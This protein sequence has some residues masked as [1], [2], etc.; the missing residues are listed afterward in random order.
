MNLRAGFNIIAH[1]QG[2]LLARAFVQR[3]DWPQVDTLVSWVGP[4]AGQFGVPTYEPLLGYMNRL[5]SGLWY[6]KNLQS[7]SGRTL[8]FSNYW[9][10]PTKLDMYRANSGFLA[11]INNE[12][13]VKN[14]SYAERLARLSHF[15]LVY[16][17]ADTIIQPAISSWFGFYKDNS[18]EV[19]EPLA[20]RK[21][22]TEDWIGLKR[23]D[24]TGRLH[25]GAVDCPH[26]G[27]ATARCKLQV[28]DQITKG[29]LAP[30]GGIEGLLP[31]LQGSPAQT[32]RPRGYSSSTMPA[33]AY[34]HIRKDVKPG[35]GSGPGGSFAPSASPSAP[36]E[37]GVDDDDDAAGYESTS[38]D[39][40]DGGGGG[41]GRSGGDGGGGGHSRSGGGGRDEGKRRRVRVGGFG[42]MNVLG[43]L[44]RGSS[45]PGDQSSPPDYSHL[46]KEELSKL[47][48]ELRREME[49]VERAEAAAARRGENAVQAREAAE[50]AA[51]R[52][53]EGNAAAKAKAAAARA[54]QAMLEAEA[55][56]AAELAKFK[57]KSERYALERLD[58]ARARAEALRQRL[59]AGLEELTGGEADVTKGKRTVQER[60]REA[61]QA[62]LK[63]R[64]PR[65]RPLQEGEKRRQPADAK[66]PMVLRAPR[67]KGALQRLVARKDQRSGSAESE[68]AGGKDEGR[69]EEASTRTETLAEQ[70]MIRQA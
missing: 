35:S 22:Y 8:S 64:A 13:D 46:S 51:K 45:R 52:K 20:A 27:V 48:A 16:S 54:E 1:S 9:R 14:A 11:D 31:W 36:F 19:L 55:K 57:E 69:N 49:E 63:A 44:S 28:W 15:V 66:R 4:Q 2:T 26:T 7:E 34:W 70:R 18:S 68:G 21:L 24:T 33:E 65:E 56:A 58:E 37:P 40:F 61:S 17:T 23:L 6:D 47:H 32:A 5:V 59:E 53:E 41:H 42:G 43:G 67:K 29:F 60:D 62:P 3:Y 12:R 25:F 30:K 38:E 10:D 50:R 39:D